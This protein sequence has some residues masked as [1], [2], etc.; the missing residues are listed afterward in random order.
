MFCPPGNIQGFA[1]GTMDRTL[2]LFE[3]SPLGVVAPPYSEP[4]TGNIE[5]P[6]STSP[7]TGMP[8]MESWPEM[9]G[10]TVHPTGAT[11]P[12]GDPSVS[13]N[14]PQRR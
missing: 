7:R 12:L 9:G 6:V 11:L 14:A 10:A 13:L 5:A 4:Q 1:M 2:K 3:S 8:S